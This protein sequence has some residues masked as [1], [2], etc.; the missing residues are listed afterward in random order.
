MSIIGKI[1]KTLPGQEGDAPKKGVAVG[2][3]KKEK[4]VTKKATREPVSSRPVYA[5]R[6]IESPYITEKTSMLAA[7]N[8]YVFKVE[9]RTTKNEI[10]KAVHRMF[11]VTVTQV[12]IMNMPGKKVRLGGHEGRVPG[13]KKAVVTIKKGETIDIG[14]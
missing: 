6:V 11:K 10:I 4:I 5:G 9:R 8:K 13:F 14:V 2:G 3:V 7:E 12:N 1:K